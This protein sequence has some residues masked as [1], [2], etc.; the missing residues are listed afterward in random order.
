M[1][2]HMDILMVLAALGIAFIVFFAVKS[3]NKSKNKEPH[4]AN[5][6]PELGNL[7]VLYQDQILSVKK[8]QDAS[9]EHIEL[10][11]S[12][13]TQVTNSAGEVFVLHVMAQENNLFKGYELLQALLSQGLRFGDMNIFHRYQHTNGKGNV[14]FSLTSAIEPG[15]F[16]IHNMGSYSCPGL[17]LFMQSS[18]HLKSDLERFQLMVKVAKNIARELGGIC[19]SDDRQILTEVIIERYKNRINGSIAEQIED[20][21]CVG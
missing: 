11:E 7:D 4:D 1:Q 13:N 6:E 9:V 12:D 14:L 19:Q 10:S 16:D 15:T 3:F 5:K 18:G 20:V 21:S 17:S 8:A 2:Q